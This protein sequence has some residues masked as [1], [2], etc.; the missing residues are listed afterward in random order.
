MRITVAKLKKLNACREAVDEFKQQKKDW[1]L[2]PLLEKM[3]KSEKLDWANWLIV[4]CMKRKQY[5]AYAIYAA[6]QVLNIFEKK[7]PKD[8]RPR[9]A[10][11]AAEK[12]LK[13]DTK[14][15]RVDADTY[16]ADTYAADAADAAAYAAAYD[17]A[18]YAER[19]IQA[20]KVREVIRN[21]WR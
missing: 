1:K 7:Y 12:V 19:K 20:D 9:K 18:A 3:I 16:D 21:P 8:K 10:I 17:A 4:R 11:K 13:N 6:R 2:I 15:N 5:L 14:K